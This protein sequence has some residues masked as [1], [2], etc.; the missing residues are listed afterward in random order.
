MEG[1]EA[2]VVEAIV[3]RAVSASNQPEARPWQ[4]KL[5][6]LPAPMA[7]RV[8]GRVS[9]SGSEREP[10][11]TSSFEASG[12]SIAQYRVPALSGEMVYR[13]GRLEVN[14]F[15][16]VEGEANASVR[17]SV[18]FEG[19]A[20]LDVEVHNL[21]LSVLRPWL[22]VQRRL[23]GKGDIYATVTGAARSPRVEGDLELVEPGYG[24]VDLERLRVG[25]FLYAGNRLEL[26][27]VDLVKGPHEAALAGSLP[28]A[29]SPLGVPEEEPMSVRFD[30]AGGDLSA[31]EAF[32]PRVVA[33]AGGRLEASYEQSGT[34]AHPRRRGELVIEGGEL[35]FTGDPNKF[36][37]EVAARL[38]GDR[39]VLGGLPSSPEEGGARP[40]ITIGSGEGT[41]TASGE[42]RIEEWDWQ[43]FDRNR[44]DLVIA[45]RK[46]GVILGDLLHGELNADL[47]TRRDEQSGRLVIAAAGEGK[48]ITVANARIRPPLG[49]RVVLGRPR[50]AFNP[51]LDIPVSLGPNVSLVTPGGDFVLLGTGQI[52]GRLS[53]DDLVLVGNIHSSRGSVRFPA[54][55]LQL[56]RGLATI[57]K[58][59]GGDPR[60]TLYAEMT[61]RVE[62]YRITLAASGAVFPQNSLRVTAT[63]IPYLGEREVYALLA[64]AT[65]FAGGPGLF[66]E[67]PRVALGQQFGEILTTGLSGYGFGLLEQKLSAAFGLEELSVHFGVGGVSQVRIGERLGKKFLL[68]YA[69]GFAPQEPTRVT[70]LSYEVTPTVF[71]GWSTDEQNRSG[72]DVETFWRF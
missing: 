49:R 64:G 16:A 30:M 25:K 56:T 21:D 6:K 12:A 5:A 48:G 1:L 11:I 52:G 67:N 32:F 10:V 50:F 9:V 15:S 59:A 72:A 23:A 41:L 2:G 19:E 46:F 42:G 20:A 47:V 33:K 60:I 68:S 28:L 22:R 58:E 29:F 13:P 39:L 37:L 66:P 70:R 62:N 7:G 44:L 54:A 8:S 14:R 57:L 26:D 65:T 71:L 40:G 35:Q 27:R 31:L 34:R 69:S 18:D 43:S 55:P 24:D 51:G 36:S 63:S 61:G 3:R 4:A 38:E 45:A 17:G 53:Y